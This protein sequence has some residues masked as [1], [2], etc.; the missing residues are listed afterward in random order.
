MK[1]CMEND[2]KSQKLLY[3]KYL[4]YALRISYRYVHSFENAAHAAN[5]AF[6]K[7]FKNFK[8]FEIRDY[9]HI[10][11][12][13]LGWIRRIVINASIDFMGRENLVATNGTVH[14][15]NWE[16]KGTNNDG[17]NQLVYKELIAL[18]KKLSPAYKV[19]FNLYVID[20]YTHQEIA[21]MLGISVG[22]SKSNL[23]KARA[24][25]Q[26]YLVKDDKGNILCFT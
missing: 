13:L 21:D 10:E 4:P 9:D 15:D 7:I 14:H 20:G 26:K 22:T 18:I 11:S 8:K 12:M 23:S 5:D 2:A 17:E 16:H 3:D 24:F 19:V 1:G 25:L 6:V